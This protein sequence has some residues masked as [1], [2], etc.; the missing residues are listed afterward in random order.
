MNRLAIAL[1][2]LVM[3]PATAGAEIVSKKDRLGG[4]DK[5]LPAMA[6][7]KRITV[8][9]GKDR[10]YVDLELA[11]L[12]AAGAAFY[13]YATYTYAD[14]PD[15]G[16]R[17]D[18]D[19]AFP[20]DLRT[21]PVDDDLDSTK[22]KCKGIKT[23]LLHAKRIARLSVPHACAGVPRI[24]SVTVSGTA[25]GEAPDPEEPEF[26]EPVTDDTQKITAAHG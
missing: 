18:W 1:L 21:Y 5:R 24:G 26:T 11:R 23:R 3:L 15:T 9:N 6:D 20:P 2:A 4:E 12:P 7:I 8:T 10:L 22:V 14:A 19:S 13:Y 17:L 25:V 16:F